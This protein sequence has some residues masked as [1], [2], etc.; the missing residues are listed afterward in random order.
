MTIGIRTG[1][2]PLGAIG[3]RQNNVAL[4]LAV[5]LEIAIS[6]GHRAPP[7]NWRAVGHRDLPLRLRD[8]PAPT[9]PA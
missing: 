8:S 7:D 1:R 3:F 6:S 2:Q 9:S 4:L 5:I